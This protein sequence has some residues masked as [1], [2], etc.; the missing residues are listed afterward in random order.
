MEDPIG[1]PRWS[2]LLDRHPA[3]S[4]FHSPGWLNA[5]RQT[6]GYEPFVVTTSTGPTLENGMVVCRVKGWT[7]RRLVSLPFSDHCDPLVDDSDDLSEMLDVPGRAGADGRLAVG[8][9]ASRTAGQ[10]LEVAAR[11][12]RSRTRRRI[13]LA[14]ARPAAGGY[15]DL[16][17]DAS[18]EHAAGHSPRGARGADLRDGDVRPIARELLPAAADD[19]PAARLAAAA[20][21]LVS[22]PGD[23]SRRPG[24]DSRGAART[25]SR[26]PAS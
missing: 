19:A 22:Q 23:V 2:E 20:A 7:S 24:C 8:G 9:V 25:A 11:R 26:S 1:D 15:G 5:L 10:P 21:R 3:A 16:S 18:L 13:L 17:A 12:V 4:I 14:P 6:Y